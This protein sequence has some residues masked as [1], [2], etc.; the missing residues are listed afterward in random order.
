MEESAVVKDLVLRGGFRTSILLLAAFNGVLVAS[1][2]WRWAQGDAP[3]GYRIGTV[4]F[5]LLFFLKIQMLLHPAEARL[6]DGRLSLRL[7]WGMACSTPRANVALFEVVDGRLRV[8]FENLAEV[9]V[10]PGLR[11]IFEQNLAQ[12][13][14]HLRIPMRMVGPPLQAF[15]A[16]LFAGRPD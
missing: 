1:G 6:I 14:V 11:R 8:R 12:G 13:G 7:G 4:V 9:E 3:L 10:G 2:A 16:A 15:R 5:A